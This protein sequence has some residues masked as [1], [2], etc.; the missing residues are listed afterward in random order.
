M[1][2]IRP[3]ICDTMTLGYNGPCEGLQVNLQK[4]IHV[5]RGFKAA[6]D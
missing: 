6:E 3:V 5:Y 2:A 1:F 4:V